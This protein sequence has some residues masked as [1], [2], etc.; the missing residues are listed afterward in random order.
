MWWCDSD[1]DGDGDGVGDGG[2]G[3][4]EGGNGVGTY[5]SILNRC[6]KIL[7]ILPRP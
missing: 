7:V 2:D 1:G 6:T 5:Y 4:R 3:G